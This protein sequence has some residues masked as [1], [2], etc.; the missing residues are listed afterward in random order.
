MLEREAAFPYCLAALSGVRIAAELPRQRLDSL[1]VVV[2]A[3]VAPLSGLV[4][5]S[6]E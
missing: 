6:T 4:V 3:T 5:L 1:C 2:A